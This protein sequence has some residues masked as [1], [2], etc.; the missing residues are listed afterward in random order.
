MFDLG[1]VPN[2][3]Q[4]FLDGAHA[5]RADGDDLLHLVLRQGFKIRFGELLKQQVVAKAADG[6][7]RAFLLTQNAVSLCRESSSRV[8]SRR[9]FRGLWDRILP[10]S[11]ATG[12]I[13]G[14]RRR[15]EVPASE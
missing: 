10:C 15:W 3:F 4:S 14:C 13:P 12:S 7:A 9:R 11:L 2:S 6:I 1:G 8:R 5:M